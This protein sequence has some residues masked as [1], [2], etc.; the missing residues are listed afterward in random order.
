MQLA[1]LSRLLDV[2]AC[3]FYRRPFV[4]WFTARIAA[5]SLNAHTA[6][7][8]ANTVCS[9]FARFARCRICRCVAL[10]TARPGWFTHVWHVAHTVC[11]VAVVTV[12]S[13]HYCHYPSLHTHH[14][15]TAI[16]FILP[17]RHTLPLLPLPGTTST[18][19][20]RSPSATFCAGQVHHV[21]V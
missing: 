20:S 14:R 10:P 11:I 5:F 8:V 3:R 1:H 21:L 15:L 17:H 18:L 2:R 19:R 12:S 9:T 7:Y 16:P 4:G 6:F 13:P